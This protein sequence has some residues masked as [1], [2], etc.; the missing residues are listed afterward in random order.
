MQQLGILVF[1]AGNL[2]CFIGALKK[3]WGIFL[4]GI[5]IMISGFF[6]AN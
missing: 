5:A 1:V 4:S 6:I 2:L 3:G